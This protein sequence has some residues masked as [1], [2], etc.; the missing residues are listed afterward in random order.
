VFQAFR[1]AAHHGVSR[2]F[3]KIYLPAY[4]KELYIA[5]GSKN[6]HINLATSVVPE[7]AF[8]CA[9]TGVSRGE[10]KFLLK[11]MKIEPFDDASAAVNNRS[12]GAVQLE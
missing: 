8:T 12:H 10:V 9:A 1:L 11:G 7:G 4:I 5:S 2:Y 6:I 3:N